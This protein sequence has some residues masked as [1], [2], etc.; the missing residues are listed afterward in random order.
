MIIVV[1]VS[2]RYAL[3]QFLVLVVSMF[4]LLRCSIICRKIVEPDIFYFISVQVVCPCAAV[5]F[6]F[7][8]SV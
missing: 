3:C 7:L 4:Y 2:F 1:D 5:M 8:K 6:V